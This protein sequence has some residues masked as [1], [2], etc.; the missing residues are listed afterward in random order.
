VSLSRAKMQF[1]F[2]G[3]EGVEIQFLFYFILFIAAEEEEIM[4]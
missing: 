3:A 1:H 2:E 4:F